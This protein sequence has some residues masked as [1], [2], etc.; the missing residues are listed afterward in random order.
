MEQPS[1][2]TSESIS[3]AV[4]LQKDFFRTGQTKSK[5]YRKRMLHTLAVQV[6]KYEKEICNALKLDLNKS[7]TE[8]FVTEIGIL[9]EEIKFTLKHL[10]KWMKPEKVKTA[11]T[12]I[13][14]KGIRVAEPY[15]VTL[16]IAPWN[17]PFQ[18]QLAPLIGAI[19]AGNTAILKPS[20]LTPH[21]SALLSKLVEETFDP[22]Y[23]AV[24]EGGVSTTSLLLDQ[25]FDYIFFTG[26]VPV[27]KIVME[28][29]AKRLI[30]VTL[31]LG[32]KSPC[33]VD[34]TANLELAAKRILFGKLINAGQTC[35]A[36]DYLFLHQGIKKPF[37]K[38]LKRVIV[39]FYGENAI[40]NE[41]FTKIVNHRHFHRLKRY[42]SDGEVLFGGQTDENKLKINPTLIKPQDLSSPLMTEEIFGP[43]LPILEYD[44]IQEVIDFINSRPKPLALYLFTTS[45]QVE[46]QVIESTSFGGGCINDTLMHIA[47]PYLPFGGVGESGM[48]TYHGEASFQTFSHFKSVL[49]QTNRF[50][51]SFR[52]PNA[53]NSLKMMKKLMK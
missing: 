18:L 7:E 26:S 33:I 46:K 37:I 47:T 40:E 28:A 14:S 13:G 5:D 3:A 22:A 48:G 42:L 11:K 31:E 1:E 23:V 19:A 50:D 32:G 15:G 34:K 20:E 39:N 52:Y 2:Q 49:K 30:P 36:P 17:Y 29:A 25:P 51:F 9:L 45:D 43:I 4:Q 12:H 16:I 6:R 24:L 53:K 38:E 41:E 44:D 8:A 10:D 35:I 27:G 21:T